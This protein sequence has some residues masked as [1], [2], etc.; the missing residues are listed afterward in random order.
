MLLTV[1]VASRL[2]LALEDARRTREVCD[3]LRSRNV[4][5]TIAIET[6]Q[7]RVEELEAATQRLEAVEEEARVA[8]VMMALD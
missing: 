4:L 7:K 6:A 5:L 1:G 2:I 8:K 3:A